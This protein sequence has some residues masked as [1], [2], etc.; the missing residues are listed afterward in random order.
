MKATCCRWMPQSTLSL[1]VNTPKKKATKGRKKKAPKLD[2]K[3]I[4]PARLRGLRVILRTARMKM[5]MGIHK[6]KEPTK[7]TPLSKMTLRRRRFGAEWTLGSELSPK[8]FKMETSSS[9]KMQQHRTKS[10]SDR[11]T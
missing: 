7:R 6:K 4:A 2:P 11:R 5:K 3:S 10:K 1:K 9:S 8:E